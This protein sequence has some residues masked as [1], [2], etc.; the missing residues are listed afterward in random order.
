MDNLDDLKALWRTAKTDSLPSSKEM[1][2]LVSKFRHQKLRSKWLVIVS[3]CLLALVIISILIITDFKMATTYIGGGLMAISALLLAATNI[4]SLKR[5][6]QLEDCSNLEFLAFIE[7]TRQNQI[8]Y[9]KKTM[10]IIVSVCVVGWLLYF[11][12]FA[13]QHPLWLTGIYASILVYLAIMWFV[14]RPRSFKKDQAKLNATQQRLEN[15]S[16]QLKSY[17]T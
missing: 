1:R 8:Y 9:Y 15:I 16:N 10:G 12:E 14:V 5:F 11:Y 17:E 7:Q 6:Y 4:K 2:Q 13:Y 3:S